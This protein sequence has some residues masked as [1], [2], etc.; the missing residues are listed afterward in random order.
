MKLPNEP[1]D[2]NAGATLLLV[3]AL[4]TVSACQSKAPDKVPLGQVDT[5]A[6]LP[7]GHPAVTSPGDLT[8]AARVAL[9][10]GNVAFKAKNY[11]EALRLYRVAANAVPEHAAPWFGVYM[12]AKATGNAALGDSAMKEVQKRTP[13]PPGAIDSAMR[14]LHPAAV[15]KAPAT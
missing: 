1:R 5:T 2:R 8:P 12:V 15:K 11:A 9:D 14:G 10:S 7:S 3:A 6:A 4:F 13:A